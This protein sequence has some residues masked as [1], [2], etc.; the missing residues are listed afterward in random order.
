[1]TYQ[2]FSAQ[3]S[4][5]YGYLENFSANPNSGLPA[6]LGESTIT[7]SSG[8][9]EETD[10][11]YFQ[12]DFDNSSGSGSVT[13]KERRTPLPKVQLFVLFL[14]QFA[15]PITATVIYPFVNQFVRDTG[16]IGGD[17]RKTGYYAG[18]IASQFKLSFLPI[19]HCYFRSRYFFWQKLL[20]SSS[21][22]GFQIV[23]AENPYY[24][25][26]LLVWPLPCF[27]L[28]CRQPFGRLSRIGACKASSTVISVRS[29]IR[30][31]CG[32]ALIYVSLGVSKTVLGEVSYR[33]Q[34]HILTF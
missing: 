22:D 15:E 24:S 12:D 11:A 19:S 13:P 10:T 6:K 34:A 5:T 7:M 4:F 8:A 2:R 30:R 27:A 14:I 1:M 33:E 9:R 20:L 23:M 31:I 29:I 25:W 16:I 17:E 18:I 28:A 26:D 21:G 3:C 32:M